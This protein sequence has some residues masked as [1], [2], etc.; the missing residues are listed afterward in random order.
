MYP[1]SGHSFI[2]LVDIFS[3]G[4]I[5]HRSVG[6]KRAHGQPVVRVP[7]SKPQICTMV[8]GKAKH[9]R[10]PPEIPRR[11]RAIDTGWLVCRT[12][13]VDYDCPAK[14]VVS[15]RRPNITII[16]IISLS[17][18]DVGLGR[19][20]TSGTSELSTNVHVFNQEVEAV[21]TMMNDRQSDLNGTGCGCHCGEL[22]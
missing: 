12:S 20:S 13:R 7:D 1:R 8:Y 21:K 22:V 4:Q 3:A 6:C 10:T 9:W 16:Y 19:R 14:S 5:H 17:S 11:S 15:G 2:Y 18:D